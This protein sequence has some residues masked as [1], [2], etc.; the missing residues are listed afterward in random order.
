MRSPEFHFLVGSERR[1]LTIHAG[2]VQNLSSPLYA[3]INNGHMEESLSREA[4]LDD[5][6]E[7]TFIAFCEYG[8]R[9][10]YSS[11]SRKDNESES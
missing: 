4:V 8:Y 6:D 9:G 5:I 2:L 11:P 1:L 10:S 3:L 7:D